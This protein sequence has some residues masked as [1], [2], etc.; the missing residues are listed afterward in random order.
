MRLSHVRGAGA[1]AAVIAALALGGCGEDEGDGSS[2]TPGLGEVFL[3]EYEINPQN[4]PVEKATKATLTVNNDGGE[5]HALEVE[6]P[7]GEFKTGDIQPGK[8]AKLTVDATKPGKYEYYCP[9][10]GHKAGGMTGT[11]TVQ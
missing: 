8:S 2:G 11:L 3:T 5:V 9:V 4:L 7:G 1:L 10:D 6:G